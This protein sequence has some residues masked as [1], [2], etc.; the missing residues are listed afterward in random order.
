MNNPVTDGTQTPGPPL[1]EPPIAQPV[2]WRVSASAAFVL[3][4][5]T[6]S[7]TA[8]MAETYE[9]T[10]PAIDNSRNQM[11]LSQINQVL[12]PQEY[13][14]ALL[15]D[16]ITIAATP[17]TLGT[18]A[19]S[20][21]WRARKA[22]QPVA[23]IVEASAPDGYAGRIDFIMAV[24]ADESLAALRVTGHRETPG[25]GDYIELKKDRNKASPWVFQFNHLDPHLVPISQWRVKKD[26]GVIDA[27]SGA[28]I[29]ARALTN[30]A[31]RAQTWVI[32]HM[33]QLYAAASSEQMTFPP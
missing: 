15:D 19:P 22:G 32:A 18:D 10:L 26:G 13:D 1:A 3:L 5:F 7:F 25:L 28:T 29:S 14:N 20:R 12:P 21:I 33:S 31:A 8:M 4:L 11:R 2:A 27:R 16:V 17:R 9:L 23:L 6:L 30:A 24:R